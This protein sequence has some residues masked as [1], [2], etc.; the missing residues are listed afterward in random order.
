MKGDLLNI[1]ILSGSGQIFRTSKE[2]MPLEGHERWLDVG[3][4]SRVV[5]LE[6]RSVQ[7][8]DSVGIWSDFQDFQGAY[9]FGRSEM[10]EV[11]E[12][13]RVVDLERRSVKHKDSVGIWSDLSGLPRGLCLWKVREGRRGL[14]GSGS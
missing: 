14:K 8:Q 7:Y 2:F 4:V 11:E 12:V 1:R 9:A 10:L 13:L 3:E 5:D 6:R